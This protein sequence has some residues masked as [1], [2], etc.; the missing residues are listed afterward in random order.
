[1]SHHSAS[2]HA[3]GELSYGA[4]TPGVPVFAAID[5]GTNN[6]RLLIASPQAGGL[7]V[8]D[9][10]SRVVRLGEGVSANAAL[11]PLA[12]DRAVEALKICARKL[13]RYDIAAGRYV[14]TEACRRAKNCE[15]FILRIKRE[16]GLF[17][18]IIPHEEEARLAFT[19]CTPLI[20]KDTERAI[21]IDI[22]GG[23]TE[24]MWTA[25][26]NGDH[27]IL[28]LDSTPCGVMRLTEQ[29]GGSG[30]QPRF[31]DMVAFVKEHVG[32]FDASHGIAAALGQTGIQMLCTSGTVTTIA[33]IYLNLSRYDRAQV[34]GL[35]LS[36]DSI[37]NVIATILAMDDASLR[38]HPCMGD[39]RADFMV[40]GCA[41]LQAI[42][43]VWPLP[44]I[45]IGDRGV[46]EGIV[47][48]LIRE[49]STGG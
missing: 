39:D 11:S 43:D 23:S 19:G 8:L 29:F 4:P 34:D 35:R 20:R 14:A 5:L 10:F 12:M 3:G 27:R 18:E 30:L 33:A 21:I 7:Q 48:T 16:T 41:I 42:L 24:C 38:A 25:R 13:S 49:Q 22:G 6:C 40:A 28:A 31:H 45:T 26:E 46:R 47:F 17:V 2:A 15:D 37:R 44:E 9:T 1:M 32:R 36:A